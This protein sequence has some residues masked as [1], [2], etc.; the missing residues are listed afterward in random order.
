MELVP[1]AM[2]AP[3]NEMKVF[4]WRHNTRREYAVLRPAVRELGGICFLRE[5]S[6]TPVRRVPADAGP[7]AN[8]PVDADGAVQQGGPAESTDR[9]ADAIPMPTSCEAHS[10]ER[11]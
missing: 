2:S 9:I 11:V 10:T 4:A 1:P 6:R 3:S 5:A 7:R 8:A